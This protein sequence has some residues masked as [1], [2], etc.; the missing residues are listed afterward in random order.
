MSRQYDGVINC[1]RFHQKVRELEMVSA[2]LTIVTRDG[3]MTGQRAALA[4]HPSADPV[5]PH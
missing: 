5:T 3:R 1:V 4:A 2:S